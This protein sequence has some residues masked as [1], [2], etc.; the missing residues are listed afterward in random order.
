[1]E[2]LLLGLAAVALVTW[3][4][5]AWHRR[6]QLRAEAKAE[7]EA[8]AERARREQAEHQA[9]WRPRPA[10]AAPVPAAFPAP[11]PPPVARAPA[12]V[13]PLARLRGGQSLFRE[14]AGRDDWCVIDTETTGLGPQDQVIEVAVVAPD[15]QVLVEELVMPTV[16]ISRKASAKHGLTKRSLAGRPYWSAVHHRV[17]DALAGRLVVAYNAEYDAR[18]L[19]Q[20]AEAWDLALPDC[21]WCCAMLAYAAEIGEP[22]KWRQGEYRWWKLEEALAGEGLTA[23]ASHRALPDAEAARQLILALG[24]RA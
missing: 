13:R 18:L 21:E 19:R 5:A 23:S 12:V 4:V 22:H 17:R 14:L 24:R 1:M 11:A 8:E 2:Y 10:M 15:G 3:R 16:A 9:Q 6:R 20:T 7:A